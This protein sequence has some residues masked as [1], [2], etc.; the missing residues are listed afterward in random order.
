[1]STRVPI[2][3][4]SLFG[5]PLRVLADPEEPTPVPDRFPGESRGPSHRRPGRT[6]AWTSASA[7]E[8]AWVDWVN[9]ND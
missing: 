9:R 8:A 7:G 5:R 2:L 3:G 6:V 4:F 1:M